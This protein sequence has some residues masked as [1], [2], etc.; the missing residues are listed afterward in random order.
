LTPKAEHI[1]QFGKQQFLKWHQKTLLISS[2]SELLERSSVPTSDRSLIWRTSS[3]SAIAL[4]L[5]VKLGS[6]TIAVESAIEH[7]VTMTQLSIISFES[8][9]ALPSY[10]SGYS[11]WKNERIVK[12]ID[13]IALLNQFFCSN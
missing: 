7:L 9:L 11:I 13:V 3:A 5:V 12:V 8:S 6:Q 10:C 1:V 2:L 4:M